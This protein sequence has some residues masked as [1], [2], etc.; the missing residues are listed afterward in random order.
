[1]LR[2]LY[3]V[4][5]SKNIKQKIRSDASSAYFHW[6][7]VGIRDNHVEFLQLHTVMYL[8]RHVIHRSH[9]VCTLH[10]QMRL[11]AE[12]DIVSR[13]AQRSS[14][15]KRR[16]PVSRIVLS[17]GSYLCYLLLTCYLYVDRLMKLQQLLTPTSFQWLSSLF[18]NMLTEVDVT[19][20]IHLAA[21]STHQSLSASLWLKKILTYLST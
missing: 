7:W 6:Q 5:E 15:E 3:G 19:I 13:P 20:S 14:V 21:C 9:C 11:R 10:M 4:S 18:L 12:R 1:M 8:V 2:G 16:L 17:T